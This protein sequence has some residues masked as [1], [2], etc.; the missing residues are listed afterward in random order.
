MDIQIIMYFLYVVLINV[1]MNG[2]C[3][4]LYLGILMVFVF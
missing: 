2:G 1:I 4:V 3:V